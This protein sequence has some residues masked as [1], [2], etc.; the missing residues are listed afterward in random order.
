[1]LP[2][3]NVLEKWT[4]IRDLR[5]QRGVTNSIDMLYLRE[6]IDRMYSQIQSYPLLNNSETPSLERLTKQFTE[7]VI[8]YSKL[9][10]VEILKNGQIHKPVSKSLT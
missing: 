5:P 9:V 4:A 1:M 6:R 10:T 7:E 8:D 3:S 2:Y